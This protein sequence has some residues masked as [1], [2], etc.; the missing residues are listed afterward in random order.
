L[1]DRRE[2]LYKQATIVATLSVFPEPEVA[3]HIK[4]IHLFS[5]GSDHLVTRP[6]YTESKVALTTSS[7]IHGPMISEWIILQILANSHKQRQLLEW[8]KEHKWPKHGSLGPLTD[9]VGQRLGVLGYGS[10]GRQGKKLRTSSLTWI[11]VLRVF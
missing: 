1:T 8:Q 2:G 6:I 4:F 3:K 10:I 7:G 9:A 11:L 5:A